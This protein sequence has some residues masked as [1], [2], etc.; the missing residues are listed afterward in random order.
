MTVY[1]KHQ[2]AV[3]QEKQR[4]KDVLK[5]LED[6]LRTKQADCKHNWGPRVEE[7]FYALGETAPGKQ[8]EKCG[9]T[10]H[11]NR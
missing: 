7:M 4:H 8:C 10:K 1:E 6:E 2:Q 11:V 5:E 9:A 3:E